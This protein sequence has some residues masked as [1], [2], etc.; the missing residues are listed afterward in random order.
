MVLAPFRKWNSFNNSRKDGKFGIDLVDSMLNTLQT[1]ELANVSQL[2][3]STWKHYHTQWSPN[4]I[5]WFMYEA[6]VKYVIQGPECVKQEINP[7]CAKFHIFPKIIKGV[8]FPE[9]SKY[10]ISQLSSHL[11]LKYVKNISKSTICTFHATS[12]NKI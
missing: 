3:T 10:N 6:I 1:L 11:L 4:I 7:I 5:Q 8:Q 2:F 9:R 12:Q